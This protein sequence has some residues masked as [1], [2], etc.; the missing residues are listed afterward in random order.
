MTKKRKSKCDE[1][2]FMVFINP[3][4]DFKSKTSIH[5]S[6]SQYTTC[7]QLIKILAICHD[8]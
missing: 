2:A 5:F 4:I 3:M 6:A 7:T 8:F 1:A